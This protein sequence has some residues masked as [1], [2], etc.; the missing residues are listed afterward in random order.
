MGLIM[1]K[2]VVAQTF[3][4]QGSKIAVAMEN[5]TPWFS[6]SEV[7]KWLEIQNAP[8]AKG[9]LDDDEFKIIARD[10][11]L[12]EGITAGYTST[13]RNKLTKII[14]INES[15]F[16]HLVM[17]ST[18]ATDK[19][20]SAYKFRKWVT[21]EVIPS[22]RKTGSYKMGDSKG[23]AY[24]DFTRPRTAPGEVEVYSP[25]MTIADG[26]Q[27]M[28][29]SFK[30]FQ[31]KLPD[32]VATIVNGKGKNSLAN[33]IK[34]RIRVAVAEETALLKDRVDDL[35]G[36]V[37]DLIDDANDKLDRLKKLTTRMSKLEKIARAAV[38]Q[39]NMTKNELNNLLGEFT[40]F[41]KSMKKVV[42]PVK[43]EKPIKKKGRTIN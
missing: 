8:K 34:R 2:N 42:G 27:L 5:G 11:A 15:G 6:L 19:K 43:K 24:N 4:F 13:Q 37:D 22:L 7:C 38:D 36:H 25:P 39:G 18:K 31:D 35:E 26:V 3:S 16:Y 40:A 17:R 20:H 21:N 30:M 9:S 23:P 10:S 33:Q 28:Q 29:E 14:V 41:R 32:M 12:F 1:S